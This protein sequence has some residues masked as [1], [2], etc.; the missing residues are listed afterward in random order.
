MESANKMVT[1]ESNAVESNNVS[2]DDYVLPDEPDYPE[3]VEQSDAGEAPDVT[4]G[5]SKPVKANAAQLSM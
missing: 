3:D 4:T 1:R 5:D 2:D